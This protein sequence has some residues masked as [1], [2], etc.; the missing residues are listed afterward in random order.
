V[1]K[2]GANAIHIIAHSMGSRTLSYALQTLVNKGIAPALANVIFAAPDIDSER[3]AQFAKAIHGIPQRVTL[4]AS[5]KDRALE[6]SSLLHGLRAG[7]AGSKIVRV[8]GIDTIDASRV[9]S[10]F[11]GH[12]KF[13]ST[14]S[15][16]TD[17]YD[18]IFRG[19]PPK[20]RNL[21]EPVNHGNGIYWAFKRGTR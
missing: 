4:Y 9:N 11:L 3:F 14:Q 1:A 2:T 15:L 20:D 21:L 12:G 16:L 8:D 13:A 18:L 17:I 7:L 19:S 6:L 10:D 5:S